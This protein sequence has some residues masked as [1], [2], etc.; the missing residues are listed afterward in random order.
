MGFQGI[1]RPIFEEIRQRVTMEDTRHSVSS[2]GLHMC[3]HGHP[4]P[5]IH[6]HMPH[7]VH[8]RTQ[9]R[10]N[11]SSGEIATLSKIFSSICIPSQRY[12]TA[13]THP[14]LRQ[15]N[16]ESRSVWTILSPKPKTSWLWQFMFVIIEFGKLRQEDHSKF[17]SRLP[18]S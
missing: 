7:P 6:A 11:R 16:Y 4:H 8:M 13:K 10:Q 18:R 14:V 17:K 3:T 9:T 15:E 1:K 12:S 5:H 2:S